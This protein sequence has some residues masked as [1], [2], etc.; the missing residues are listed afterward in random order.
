LNS[1]YSRSC[2]RFPSKEIQGHRIQ[3]VWGKNMRYARNLTPLGFIASSALLLS[4][5]A[6]DA[7]VAEADSQEG[8]A[9]VA[10][11]DEV[12][13]AIE[14]LEPVEITYQGG[15]QSPHSVTAMNDFAFKE[16][17][18]ERSNGQISVEIIWGQAIAGYSEIEDALVDGR[19]DV[20]Y[21]VPV[22][23]PNE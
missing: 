2:D 3:G 13:E 11:L 5:C 6:G 23:N 20:A 7:G 16:Y 9:Y 8:F 22:Y 19:I 1:S 21:A 17:V 18:E 10:S 14:D 12:A 4:A 15:A